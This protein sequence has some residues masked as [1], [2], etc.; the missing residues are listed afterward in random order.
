MGDEPGP[1]AARPL[2][3]EVCRFADLRVTGARGG[4]VAGRFALQF[5][6]RVLERGQDAEPPQGIAGR[7]A[8]EIVIRDITDLR[9]EVGDEVL[10]GLDG[11]FL[12]GT[13]SRER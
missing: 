1:A 5:A 13:A 4:G 12:E 10:D 7:F 8:A 9:D 2:T 6:D 11:Q 3:A